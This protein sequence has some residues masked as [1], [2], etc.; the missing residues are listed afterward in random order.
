MNWRDDCEGM[1]WP[2]TCAIAI[3]VVLALHYSV[4]HNA[5]RKSQAPV[6]APKS[7]D[8]Q[9]T[10]ESPGMEAGQIGDQSILRSV[11]ECRQGE[12]KVFS[13]Q[14]CGSD[15]EV[16]AIRTPNSMVATPVYYDDGGNDRLAEP[17]PKIESR[18]PQTASVRDEGACRQI[19]LAIKQIDARMRDGYSIPEGEALKDRRN[20]LTSEYYE[21]RCKHFH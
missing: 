17:A 18:M 19:E 13:D 6:V 5:V 7:L 15:A 9:L 14:R 4:P 1:F 8:P 20:T 10:A 12:A 2:A 3:I 21:L 11:F 16:R